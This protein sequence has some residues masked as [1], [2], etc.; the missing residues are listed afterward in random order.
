[1]I[2][3]L[4]SISPTADA[5]TS[6]NAEDN[7]PYQ[8]SPDTSRERFGDLITQVL[9]PDSQQSGTQSETGL[10]QTSCREGPLGFRMQHSIVG[11]SDSPAVKTFTLPSRR[12]KMSSPSSGKDDVKTDKD[13][14]TSSVSDG[15]SN[16]AASNS[17]D[18]TLQFVA[19]FSVGITSWMP[20]PGKINELCKGM[21][22]GGSSIRIE[23][24]MDRFSVG[25]TGTAS[26]RNLSKSALAGNLSTI[27]A[28]ATTL[29]PEANALNSKASPDQV[30]SVSAPS[31][32]AGEEQKIAATNSALV[33]DQP[34]SGEPQATA[35]SAAAKT[36]L[37]TP[38]TNGLMA[39]EIFH[40]T[41]TRHPVSENRIQIANM[42]KL[43]SDGGGI[44]VAKLDMTM[45]NAEKMNKIAGSAEKILP[46]NT[47]LS[48]SKNNLPTRAADPIQSP[49]QQLEP[50]INTAFLSADS[51]S[52]STAPVITAAISSS[53]FGA[54]AMERT[55]DMVILHT[56]RLQDSSADSLRVVIKPD[57]GTQLSL[58]LRQHGDNVDAQAV[59]QRGDFN[60]FN[61]HWAELQQHLEQ[62]GIRLAPLANQG[63]AAGYSGH[64]AFQQHQQPAQ[65]ESLATS[66]FA[67][68]A[69]A[70]SATRSIEPAAIP[71]VVHRGWETWA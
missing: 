58:E 11:A 34:S 10:D 52:T 48:A 41:A 6:G 5:V 14:S 46:G 12:T 42:T 15:K 1:M 63:N 33:L 62:R 26:E 23:G 40:G 47:I 51:K 8:P 28:K 50:V 25:N 64:G 3:T 22:S 43:H 70:G 61:Q 65:Q 18:T 16:P 9:S 57:A 71:A 67:E 44:F 39:A 35:V 36:L 45:K 53:D 37:S 17:Q 27:S 38:E 59:L 20:A 31:L 32:K 4:D 68:F 29:Q 56:T 66:V 55:H 2:P 21:T 24:G 69:P 13:S 7:L 30:D 54:R 49:N 19:P 60:Q